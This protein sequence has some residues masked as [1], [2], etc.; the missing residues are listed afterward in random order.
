MELDPDYAAA[1]REFGWV[2]HRCGSNPETEFHLRKAIKLE[3]NDAWAHIYLGSYLWSNA[4]ESAVAE[5]HTARALKPEWSAPL[6][7]LGNIHEFVI[8]GLDIA[9]QFFERA[10]QLE[11]DDPVAL[12]NLGRLCKKRGQVDRARELLVRAL[13][14]DPENEK[15]RDLLSEIGP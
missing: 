15:A 8:E 10:L 14:L 4:V 12:A 11:P 13:F 7:S 3:P 1:H 6:W 9:Q 2:L 5:F